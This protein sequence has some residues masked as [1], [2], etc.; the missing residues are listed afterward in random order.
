MH[1]SPVSVVGSRTLA[2]DELV[3]C[4]LE[5]LDD[6][7]AAWSDRDLQRVA[8]L[9]APEGY[10]VS[11]IA[12]E[13]GEVFL[14]R[15][16]IADHL[17]RTQNRV[18]KASIQIRSIHV[19]VLA[20]ELLLATFICRWELEWVSYSRIAVVLRAIDGAWRFIHQMES[21]FHLEDWDQ[22][23]RR[24]LSNDPGQSSS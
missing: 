24:Q 15:V 23:P 16:R 5:V 7:A 6:W 19:Q 1:G 9:W 12:D 3:K 22:E 20:P 14:D 2:S 11:Y 18:G 21:P 8:D 10:D 4:A 13:L 17:L